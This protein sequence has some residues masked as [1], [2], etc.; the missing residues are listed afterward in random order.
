M[1]TCVKGNITKEKGRIGLSRCSRERSM[2]KSCSIRWLS[3]AT[4]KVAPG[5]S[6]HNT[7]LTGDSSKRFTSMRNWAASA[8]SATR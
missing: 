5:V 3:P 8:P 2:H 1:L 4:K 7:R 6:Y